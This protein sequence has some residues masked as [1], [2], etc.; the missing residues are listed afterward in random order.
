MGTM[1][2]STG[3][4]SYEGGRSTGMDT[5]SAEAEDGRGAMSRREF[6]LGAAT[7][8]SAASV[9]SA[10][11]V[12]ASTQ[13]GA[14]DTLREV[15]DRVSPVARPP[16]RTVG[17]AGTA[18]GVD[19]R[20]GAAVTESTQG[21]PTAARSAPTTPTTTLPT[22][23][24]STTA[25]DTLLDDVTGAAEATVDDPQQ[26]VDLLPDL[27]PDAGDLP[28]V[29]DAP[30]LLTDGDLVAHV[31]SRLTFGPTKA[32][33][34][35]IQL[36]GPALWIE[37]QLRPALIPDSETDAM[38]AGY[39]TLGW[40][41]AQP[42]AGDSGL[43][44]DELRHATLLRAV[45]S[46]RQLFETMV[47]FWTN[48]LNT[49]VG[50]GRVRY[51]KT[52]EDRDVVRRHALGSFADLLV[53]SAKSPAMLEY[54]DNRSSRGANPNENYGRELLEL[55]TVGVDGGY[56]EDDVRNAAYVL[57]GWTYDRDTGEFV[58]RDDWHFD[59]P[60]TVLGWSTPGRSGPGAIADGE[61]ML[62]HLARHPN[63]ARFLAAKLA[64]RFV[65]DDPPEDVIAS[66][67]AA[68][69]D[70]DTDIAATLRHLFSTAAF[71]SGGSPKFRR[72]F[73]LVAAT[74]RGTGANIDPAPQGDAARRID[75][76]LRGFGQRLFDQPPP[77]GYPEAEVEW[78]STDGLLRR[79]SWAVE[80]LTDRIPGVSVDV[81]TLTEDRT[82]LGGGRPSTAGEL[83]D[84]LF[85]LLH[86][87]TDEMDRT[88]VLTFFDATP[89]TPVDESLLAD[90]PLA[91]ALVFGSAAAQYR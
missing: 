59:G 89:A 63:T 35:E 41:N 20:R 73:D 58:F 86:Q 81:D 11:V 55:H 53:A 57:T 40:S 79:W 31:A 33:V 70:A 80:L 74:L 28:A 69:L 52:T 14:G 51:F 16:Q 54:L 38:L 25:T 90:V 37:R 12:S 13:L 32:V 7:A 71:R 66:T 39:T 67:A 50:K 34:D 3:E 49:Y 85:S 56:T 19:R 47:D 61:G 24:T 76:T 2:R 44:L 78:V 84:R 21:T 5:E 68:Y 77:T 10:G 87:P 91:A 48:H 65:G 36:L 22:P 60:A 29:V 15:A 46:R 4:R 23:G 72:P 82:L 83:V 6:A 42:L 64:E 1:E 30:P 26:I 75:S 8:A 27:P 45:F 88:A 62:A 17:R 18:P 9:L 43:A